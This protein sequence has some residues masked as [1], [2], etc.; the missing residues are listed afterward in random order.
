MNDWRDIS[1][2]YFDIE[3]IHKACFYVSGIWECMK[4][5]RA[6]M[7]Q[8][9]SRAMLAVAAMCA[10]SLGGGIAYMQMM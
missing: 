1:A 10:I 4:K 8:K 5:G 2:A 6:E 9:K 7:N 3:I